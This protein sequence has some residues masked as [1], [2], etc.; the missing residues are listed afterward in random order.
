MASSQVN[1]E[2]HEINMVGSIFVRIG[3]AQ[4]FPYKLRDAG[5]DAAGGS[6]AGFVRKS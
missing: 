3:V 1:P 2:Q 5:H 6:V 4:D